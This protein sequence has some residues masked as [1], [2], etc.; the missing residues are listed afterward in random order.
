MKLK[1]ATILLFLICVL[2]GVLLLLKQKKAE[3]IQKTSDDQVTTLSTLSNQVKTTSARLDEQSQVNTALT[4]EVE[5]REVKIGELSNTV[6]QLAVKLEKTEADAK[7][8]EQ[9]AQAELAKRDAKINELEGMKDDMTK[10]MGNLTNLIGDLS[11]QIADTERKLAVSE[12][13]REFLLKELKR[14]Q[15]EKAELERQFN[16]L[17]V[18]KAQVSKLKEEL[19]IARRLEFVRAGLFSGMKGAEMLVRKTPPP[20][21][22]TATNFNLNV[23]FKQDGGAKVVPSTNA[24]P[25][26]NTP[27]PK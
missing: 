17:K 20:A 23:E 9:A 26:T 6:T 25:A 19:A 2:L 4:N 16:D 15:S 12:G 14:L 22:R 18:L 8:K 27:A 1:V 24:V 13:D 10:R 3:E 21:P 5:K 11:K 7:A